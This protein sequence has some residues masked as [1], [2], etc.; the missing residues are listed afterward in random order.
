MVMMGIGFIVVFRK[1]LLDKFDLNL[2]HEETS[3]MTK[4]EYKAIGIMSI[5]VV[6]WLTYG[7][8]GISPSMVALIGTII[9]FA[10]GLIG[11]K[12]FKVINIGL[13]IFLTAGF[14]I[15]KVL[16]GSGI[17]VLISNS[18]M[19]LFPDASS[20]FYY[21]VIIG[22]VSAIHMVSG[23]SITAMSIAIPTLTAVTGE[24]VSTIFIT[25]LV[26]IIVSIHYVLPMHHVT[27]MIGYGNNYYENKHV[28]KYG[29]FLTI[30]LWIVTLCIYIPWWKF[31][32][33]S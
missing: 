11:I 14:S 31:I 30:L 16:N 17:A 13:L 15:G 33:M 27:I 22:V 1:E 7:I 3:A 25:M 21:P 9:M 8:H 6:L 26:Y 19:T 4:E 10:I 2:E 20:P 12:D 28:V 32:H 29:I 24:Y 18:L 5:V 23:S